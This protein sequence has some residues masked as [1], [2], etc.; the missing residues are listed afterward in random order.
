MIILITLGIPIVTTLLFV[1]YLFQRGKYLQ[2]R[3]ITIRNEPPAPPTKFEH[4]K[5]QLE[6]R[7][8]A[9]ADVLG[10]ED[11]IIPD[12]KMQA[13]FDFVTQTFVKHGHMKPE[14]V[15]RK[16][17]ENFKLIKKSAA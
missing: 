15:A 9:V 17:V 4:A 8:W 16:V 10:R 6:M 2:K 1:L 12:E 13:V 3:G 11:W 14:R 7:V 5:G